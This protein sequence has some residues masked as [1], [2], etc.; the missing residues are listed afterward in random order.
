MVQ[1]RDSGEGRLVSAMSDLLVFLLCFGPS[2]LGGASGGFCALP[3]RLIL[4]SGFTTIFPK[5]YGGRIPA[6]HVSE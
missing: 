3:W 2:R 5:R 1:E 4:H 6:T